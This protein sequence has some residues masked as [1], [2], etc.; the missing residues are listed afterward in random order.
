MARTL[1]SIL[2]AL[3]GLKKSAIDI[4]IPSNLPIGVVQESSLKRLT[5]WRRV[6]WKNIA[7][8]PRAMHVS[9]FDQDE[10]QPCI[11]EAQ[12]SGLDLV[13]I[14]TTSCFDEYLHASEASR[15]HS[16]RRPCIVR[17]KHSFCSCRSYDLE[18]AICERRR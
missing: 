2:L 16:P 7:V 13:P 12:K 1:S 6:P 18:L 17:C 11:P 14:D 3:T 8:D 10:T 4:Q 9:R 5:S 15:L